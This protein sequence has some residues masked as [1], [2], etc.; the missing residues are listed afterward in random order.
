MNNTASTDVY[1]ELWV[2]YLYSNTEKL[3]AG[4]GKEARHLSITQ[5]SGLPRAQLLQVLVRVSVT[6]K[7]RELSENLEAIDFT[8]LDIKGKVVPVN[9]SIYNGQE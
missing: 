9:G 4:A 5:E 2:K 7:E 8:G 1:I 6:G 3:H